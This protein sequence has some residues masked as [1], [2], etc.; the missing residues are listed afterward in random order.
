M[1]TSSTSNTSTTAASL[2]TQTT[3]I[4][5]AQ[6]TPQAP[7]GSVDG[8]MT[9]PNSRGIN[10]ISDV[11]PTANLVSLPIRAEKRLIPTNVSANL[12]QGAFNQ[13]LNDIGLT[14]TQGQAQV[15]DTDFFTYANSESRRLQNSVDFIKVRLPHRGINSSSLQPDPTQAVEYRFLTNPHTL[16]VNRQTVDSQSMTRGGWQFGVWGEDAFIVQIQGTSAGSYF[17]LGT[18]DEFSYYAVSY[19]NLMQL[20]ELFENNGYW[21]EGEEANE[22]PLAPGYLRRR[23]KMHQ[24]VELWV[25]NFIWSGMF[26]SFNISQDADHPFMLNFS[27]S[28]FVWKERYRAGSPYWGSIVNNVQ[29]GHS[30]D[31]VEGTTN[32]T[33]TNNTLSQY[34]PSAVASQNTQISNAITGSS[35]PS[36]PN[37]NAQYANTSS[38]QS[39]AAEWI[40][41]YVDTDAYDNLGPQ[42]TNNLV[43]PQENLSFWLY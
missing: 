9:N 39:A 1:S 7:V 30:Y 3:P 38:V 22:G 19:R 27:L 20:Q 12:I 24:D 41:P 6:P 10:D 33:S 42:P 35:S 36:S 8:T 5:T 29:R 26:D 34:A 23:I 15:Q 28:F 13:G 11:R 16:T 2:A 21:F 4:I 14:P 17:T 40:T 31:N 25:G 43:N 37:P 18:T 32:T